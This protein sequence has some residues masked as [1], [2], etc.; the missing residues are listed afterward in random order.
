MIKLEEPII[1]KEMVEAAIYSLN[2]EFP[3]FGESVSKFEDEFARFCNVEHAIACASG[4][5]A[6]IL[7]LTAI[8]IKGKEAITTPSTY[9]S[10]AN[11]AILA[12]GKTIFADIDN[13]NNLD[14]LKAKQK[15]TKKTVAII[16]V[17]LHGYPAKMDEFMEIAKE[18][19]YV[20]EDSAQAHGALYKGKRTGSIGHIGC[21]SFNPVKNMTVAGMGGMITT[22]DD[23]IA[24]KIQ[25]LADSGRDSIFSHIHEIVGYSSRLNSVNAAIGRVQ[26]KNLDKWNESRRITAKKYERELP[27]EILPPL[28]T[29]EI[30]PVFNKFALRLKNRD[31]VKNY[32]WDK[33]I[34]CDAHYPIPVHK[35]PAYHLN[36]TYKNAEK[37]SMETLSIPMHPQISK[38]EI[39]E[40]I[41]QLQYFLPDNQAKQVQL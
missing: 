6:L 21:F 28:Q 15:I 22:N 3:L 35:Q 5:D 19:I 23:K 38:K 16:P 13:A 32:L 24:K 25:M 20:I 29:K 11:A 36:E 33:S 37:F 9:V 12:G 2:N 14:P 41:K 26:L 8:G 34:E 17:H 31:E 27:K 39:E 40:V 18:K 30:T 7:S 1:N 10:T 4:T